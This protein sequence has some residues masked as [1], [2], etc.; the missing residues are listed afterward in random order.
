M[1]RQYHALHF[2]NLIYLGESSYS[3]LFPPLNLGTVWL[4]LKRC[5]DVQFC[6][7]NERQENERVP[8]KD[9]L[10]EPQYVG[11]THRRSEEDQRSAVHC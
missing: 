6:S 2:L 8:D 3:I 5:V 4:D 9:N 11:A 7:L 1:V 10:W